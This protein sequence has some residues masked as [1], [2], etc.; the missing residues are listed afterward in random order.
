MPRRSPLT[1]AIVAGLL[2]ASTPAH[3][4]TTVR[5]PVIDS[6]GTKYTMFLPLT[7]EPTKNELAI[8]TIEPLGVFSQDAY[9]N[10][11][12][13]RSPRLVPDVDDEVL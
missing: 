6:M 5:T 13:V 7:S 10:E 11:M 3:A 12:G 2:A 8:E 9:D 4:G 1:V